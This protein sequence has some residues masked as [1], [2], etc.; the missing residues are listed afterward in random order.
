MATARNVTQEDSVW[1]QVAE[2]AFAGG[3]AAP[4]VVRGGPTLNAKVGELTAE[5]RI[6]VYKCLAKHA[7]NCKIVAAADF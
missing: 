3:N 5:C 1:L 7:I 6:I 4:V 2:D